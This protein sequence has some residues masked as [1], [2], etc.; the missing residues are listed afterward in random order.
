MPK[1]RGAVDTQISLA[2]IRAAADLGIKVVAPIPLLA[3]DGQRECFEARIADFG[4]PKGTV[5]GNKGDAGN[6]LRKRLGYYGSNL[7]PGYRIYE[8]QL[9][10][11]TLNDWGWFGETDSEPSW[12]SGKSLTE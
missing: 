4:A 3:D 9:F 7:Y 5:V 2:W 11:E 10:I 12:Y 1:P 8:R 6:D